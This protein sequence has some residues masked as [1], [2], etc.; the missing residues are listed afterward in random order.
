MIPALA[1]KAM[2]D[3]CHQLNPRPCTEADMAALY[4]QAL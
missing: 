2:E 1:K 4:E 3:A